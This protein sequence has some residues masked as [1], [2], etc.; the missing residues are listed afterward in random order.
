VDF[1]FVQFRRWHVL[2][3]A[4]SF[5]VPTTYCGLPAEGKEAVD[6]RPPTRLACAKCDK[7]ALKIADDHRQAV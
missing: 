7:T 6:V 5:T 2:R 1:Q 3:P 4:H